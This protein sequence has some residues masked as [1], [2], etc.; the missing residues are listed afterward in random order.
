MMKDPRIR[1]Y[2]ERVI[3]SL[4]TAELESEIVSPS[5]I[6]GGRPGSIGATFSIHVPSAVD[7]YKKDREEGD[8]S[9]DSRDDSCDL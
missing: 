1:E 2:W 6:P 4:K 3:E 7:M 9:C 5:P 8:D